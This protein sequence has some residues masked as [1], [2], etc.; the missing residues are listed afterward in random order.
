M[1]CFWVRI[2]I[3]LPVPYGVFMVLIAVPAVCTA[4]KLAFR[5]S[6]SFAFHHTERVSRVSLL[7]FTRLVYCCI[8][9]SYM[10]SGCCE[11]QSSHVAQILGRWAYE[12]MWRLTGASGGGCSSS[13]FGARQLRMKLEVVQ[14]STLAAIRASR[15]HFVLLAAPIPPWLLGWWLFACIGAEV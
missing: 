7:G 4:F 2:D 10:G 12:V 5:S 13:R 14:A 9:I 11:V 8:G 15:H 6:F 3:P 1:C